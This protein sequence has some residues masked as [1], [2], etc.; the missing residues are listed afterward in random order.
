MIDIRPLEQFDAGRF[1]AIGGGYTSP[2]RYTASKVETAERTT[3]TL[4]L[5]PFDQPY[6]KT[7]GQDEETEGLY[8]GFAHQGFSLGAY[9][10]NCLIGLALTEMRRWNR[11]LWIWE[12]HVDPAYR[13]QGIGRRLME[14]LAADARGWDVRA[15]ALETQSTNVPAI[16]F[17][18]RV[19]FEIDGIDLSF[20]TNHD[21][22]GGE[23]AIFMKQKLDQAG[24]EG[25]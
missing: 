13:R 18:R 9:D 15:L 20:Y 22:D 19:G 24:P 14:R 10:G 23:V 11:T 8:A 2:A 1:H 4:E 12:F 17:Y 21:A 25:V 3:I 5:V 16:A 7:W 6:Q